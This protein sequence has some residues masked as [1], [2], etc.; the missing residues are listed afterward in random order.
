MQVL[1]CM[2]RVQLR[3]QA[4]Y[5][6]ACCM[7]GLAALP[8]VEGLARGLCSGTP[9]NRSSRPSRPVQYHWSPL[10]ARTRTH[11][12]MRTH[13][14]TH[15]RTHVCPC[16]TNNPGMPA[17]TPPPPRLPPPPPLRR[18]QPERACWQAAAATRQLAVRIPP[19]KSEWGGGATYLSCIAPPPLHPVHFS[20]MGMGTHEWERSGRCT[21]RSTTQM[22]HSCI[23]CICR[24]LSTQKVHS[25]IACIC[26]QGFHLMMCL[27]KG[28]LRG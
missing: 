14:H 27:S 11:V 1:Y 18:S 25:C 13:A 10:A 28:L 22:V 16:R 2:S 15:A 24:Y 23:A 5:L 6:P 9:P 26:P 7:Q 17:A 3:Q 4:A 19:S 20:Q 12:H 21:P 8:P